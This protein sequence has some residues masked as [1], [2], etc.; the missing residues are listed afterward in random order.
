MNDQAITAIFAKYLGP[1]SS[2]LFVTDPSG[3]R[4]AV[5]FAGPAAPVIAAYRQA[6]YTVQTGSGLRKAS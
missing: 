3:N 1:D 5:A 2:V 6:G 4:W